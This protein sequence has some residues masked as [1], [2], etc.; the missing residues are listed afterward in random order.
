MSN[1]EQSA[2]GQGDSK[3]GFNEHLKED[4]AAGEV[5]QTIRPILQGCTC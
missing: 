2:G 1:P 5:F 4:K 3:S